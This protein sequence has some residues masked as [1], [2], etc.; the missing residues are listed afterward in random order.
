MQFREVICTESIIILFVCMNISLLTFIQ[1]ISVVITSPYH[2]I[3]VFRVSPFTTVLIGHEYFQ[4]Q[5]PNAIFC[6]R[7]SVL[8]PSPQLEFLIIP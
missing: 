4:Y 7:V 6:D 3:A 2:V 1:E 5:R 8:N